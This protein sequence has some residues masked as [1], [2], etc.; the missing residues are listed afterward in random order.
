MQITRSGTLRAV[1]MVVLAMSAGCGADDGSN[2][3]PGDVLGD[4]AA[5]EEVAVV[6]AVEAAGPDGTGDVPK[7][8]ATAQETSGDETASEEPGTEVAAEI[9][10]EIA[11]EPGLDVTPD[12][13]TA[14]GEEAT[15][16]LPPTDEGVE[17][18]ITCT[19]GLEPCGAGELATC[20]DV[21]N[22]SLHC[23]DCTTVCAGGLACVEKA[24]SS[25]G[26]EDLGV[27]ASDFTAPVPTCS[28]AASSG[29][30]PGQALTL[31]LAGTNVT[32][33]V[34]A[35][36]D[37]R[38]SVNG[39]LC[40][41]SAGAEL[42]TSGPADVAV[43]SIAVLGS[44]TVAETVLVDLLQGPFG[45]G[46]FWANGDAGIVVDLGAGPGDRFLV[47]ATLGSDH[48]SLG[49]F[50][51]GMVGLDVTGDREPD[52]GVNGAE[53]FAVALLAGDDVATAGGWPL[54][55]ATPE[56]TPMVLAPMAVPVA[57]FGGDGDDRFT[58]GPTA[59]NGVVVHGGPGRDIIDYGARAANL[60]VSLDGLA[61]D[62]E[63]LA[64][65]GAGEK[66]NIDGT[67]IEVVLGGSGD[68]ELMA[69]L[70]DAELHGGPG[71]DTLDGENG[72]DV[73]VGG[74][75]NDF[76]N[77][78]AG[79][80]LILESGLDAFYDPPIERGA[81]SDVI[82]GGSGFNKVDYGERTAD[83]TLTLCVNEAL[84]GPPTGTPGGECSD[85]DGD[86]LVA[87]SDNVINVQ[88]LIGGS[89]NDTLVGST[90]DETLEGGAGND[91]IRGGDGNDTLYGG[92]GDDKLYGDA[93]DDFLEGG[94]GNDQFDGGP[95]DGDLCSGDETDSFPTVN[96]EF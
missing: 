14:A 44:A 16:D 89:G 51:A 40:V 88:W 36:P 5:G 52:L 21:T 24:C 95:G 43:R 34:I 94:D 59:G 72:Y 10:A 20:V 31:A 41:N 73:L 45:P 3:E 74:P 65:G 25:V 47:R 1:A 50:E 90:G 54:P 84:V 49:R 30:G 83:L 35:A 82:N 85:Y 63:P 42:Q 75:G 28:T 18:G 11:E 38:I 6:D 81:G 93:G 46:I 4:A 58:M 67:D 7:D 27:D 22:G 86:P 64:N 96:C 69:G 77:G 56:D 17:A 33:L 55:T 92:D 8:E 37:G 19:G 87:E 71:N 76:I 68:D 48:V 57:F 26:L 62:G 32:H 15:T 60:F 66:D 80:D 39:H 13:E 2:A 61:N 91:T 70:Q 53:E 23:G 79:D 78:G 9:V 29:F 12:E